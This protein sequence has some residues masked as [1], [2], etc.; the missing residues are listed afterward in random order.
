[1]ADKPK[2]CAHPICTCVPREGDNYCSDACKDAAG[3]T[4]IECACPHPDCGGHA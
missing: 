3:L 4:D 1:M 2:K